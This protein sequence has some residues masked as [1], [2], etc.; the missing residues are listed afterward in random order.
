MI[1][2]AILAA[3]ALRVTVPTISRVLSVVAV[4][5]LSAAARIDIAAIPVRIIVVGRVIE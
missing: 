3:L 5:G 2:L 4:G 1:A